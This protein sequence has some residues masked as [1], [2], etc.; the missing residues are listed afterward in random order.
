MWSFKRRLALS[1][2]ALLASCGGGGSGSDA[3]N[4]PPVVPPP[5]KA[6]VEYAPGVQVPS[7]AESKQYEAIPEST[8]LRFNGSNAPAVG[9][10]L[11]VNGK[12]YKVTEVSGSSGAYQIGT[13]TPDFQEVFER[14]SIAEEIAIGT[15]RPTSM[16]T[17]KAGIDLPE[18]KLKNDEAEL[19]AFEGYFK[20]GRATAVFDYSRRNGIAKAKI[21]VAGELGVVARLR[22]K[23]DANKYYKEVPLMVPVRVPIPATLGTVAIKIPIKLF[24][25]AKSSVEFEIAKFEGT[26]N[27]SIGTEYN[28]LSGKFENLSSFTEKVSPLT[29]AADAGAVHGVL[30]SLSIKPKDKITLGSIMVGPVMGLQL[31]ALDDSVG[32]LGLRYELGIKASLELLGNLPSLVDCAQIPASLNHDLYVFLNYLKFES[33]L[34]FEGRSEPLQAKL[35]T[36]E[37]KLAKTEFGACTIAPAEMI[38]AWK[39]MDLP[40][41]VEIVFSD[42]CRWMEQITKEGV[43]TLG[44]SLAPGEGCGYRESVLNLLESEGYTLFYSPRRSYFK[45]FPTQA[46]TPGDWFPGY[47]EG[48]GFGT[49]LSKVGSLTLSA[50]ARRSDL[51]ANFR[52]VRLSCQFRDDPATELRGT[53]SIDG[54]DAWLAT[55]GGDLEFLGVL[56]VPE[57]EDRLVTEEFREGRLWFTTRRAESSDYAEIFMDI[58]GSRSLDWNRRGQRTRCTAIP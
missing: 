27:V 43:A 22:L 51:L 55:A 48:S 13:D 49:V 15:Q 6:V 57:S 52:D 32:V 53:L 42:N 38:P 56:P 40:Y 11:V 10:V 34:D 24:L 12:A 1:T 29:S 19:A 4:Q 47:Q 8:T 54:E 17:R 26:W 28:P 30:D 5:S 44:A 39:K 41:R 50:E 25:R 35:L 45:L 31:S 36:T 14:L 3:T 37:V 7:V 9:A 20:N 33:L 58:S 2:L 18:I 23:G 16:K 46:A 21:Q